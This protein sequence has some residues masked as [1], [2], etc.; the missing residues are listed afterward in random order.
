MRI[1]FIGLGIMGG[2]MAGHLIDAGHT[3]V[4]YDVVKVPEA[5]T[6]EVDEAA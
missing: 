5:L 3:R 6:E 4:V 2:P 1:G